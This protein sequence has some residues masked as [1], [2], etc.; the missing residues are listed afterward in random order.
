MKCPECGFESVDG[1]RLCRNCGSPLPQ[2][3]EHIDL[4]FEASPHPE[5]RKEPV[6]DETDRMPSYN[7]PAMDNQ[8]GNARPPQQPVQPPVYQATPP[9]Y[10]QAPSPTPMPAAPVQTRS[11][12]VVPLAVA[13]VVLI[14]CIAAVVVFGGFIGGRSNQTQTNSEQSTQSSA[15]N[16]NSSTTQQTQDDEAQRKA[17]EEAQAEAQRKAEEEAQAEAQRKAE[18]EAQRKAEEEAEAQRRAEEEAAAAQIDAERRSGMLSSLD[19]WWNAAFQGTTCAYISG[20]N[21]YIYK[22]DIPSGKLWRTISTAEFVRYEDGLPTGSF[23]GKPGYLIPKIAAGDKNFYITDE[24]FADGR[25]DQIAHVEDDGSG[26]DS[27]QT[28]YRCEKPSYAT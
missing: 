17:E 10:A 1:S 11:S 14:C 22:E 4:G 5:P 8:M 2:P 21:F 23:A 16:Q 27:N 13:A 15:N 20:G 18:E 9:A 26:Y 24:D 19:G 28:F 3:T 6:L 12:S 25:I 7:Y